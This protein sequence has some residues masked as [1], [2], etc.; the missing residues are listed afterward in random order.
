MWLLLTVMAALTALERIAPA[1]REATQPLLNLWAAAVNRVTQIAVAPMIA[2][3]VSHATVRLA[4]PGLHL[5]GWPL[6][7]GAAIYL[8][9]MDLG[10]YL[11]HRAQHALPWL[12]RMHT[13]HH[14]DPCMSAL[15][16]ERHFW[17][18]ALIK[19]L[20]IWPV[21]AML[22]HPSAA[23]V[24]IY[25]A[26]SLYHAFVHA[27]LPVSYGRLSWLVNSPAYHR[28]HHS[29]EPQDSGANFSALLPIFDV[30]SG[31]YRRPR[32]TPATGLAARPRNPFEILI[33]PAK[34][35]D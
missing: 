14:S 9:L 25:S 34:A 29:R 3:A 31:S 13:V 11:F 32:H 4:L 5:A 12:W 24:G 33:W 30:L 15:T 16:A 2:L 28:I 35:A 8:V 7:Y 19:G 27:N 18:D 20:T 1:R 10:E 22:T 21:V 17:G 26:A 23:I 6:V